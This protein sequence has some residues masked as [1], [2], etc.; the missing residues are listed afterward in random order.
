[1][2]QIVLKPITWDFAQKTNLF[3]IRKPTCVIPALKEP[4]SL[5]TILNAIQLIVLL[6]H[7][8]MEAKDTKE[9]LQIII[10]LIHFIMILC[11]QILQK[12]KQVHFSVHLSHEFVICLLLF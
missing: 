11:T 2:W 8:L 10:P 9:L 1:M 5:M 7:Q 3:T 12:T 4:S 6:L